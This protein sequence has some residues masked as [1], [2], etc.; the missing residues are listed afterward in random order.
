VVSQTVPAGAPVSALYIYRRLRS[1]GASIPAAGFTLVASGAVCA[2]AFGILGIAVAL[3]NGPDSVLTPV[4]AG[5]GA[6]LLVV[7]VALVRHF[8]R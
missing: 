8:L 7:A 4:L 5:T 6:L 2:V 1:W 3:G